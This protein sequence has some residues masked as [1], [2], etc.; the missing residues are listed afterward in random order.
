[1]IGG[2]SKV[3]EFLISKDGQE[4]KAE[5]QGFTGPA[6]MDTVKKLV[7]N[8]GRSTD[9][10]RKPEFFQPGGAGVSIGN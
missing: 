5:A 3:V 10:G 7:V 2:D 6:C 1:M 8:I 4:V 9:D